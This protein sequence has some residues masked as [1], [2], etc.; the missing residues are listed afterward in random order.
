VSSGSLFLR[1]FSVPLARIG[2]LHA[3]GPTRYSEG[4]NFK[5]LR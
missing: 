1:F 5:Q 4:Q 2:D 3:A